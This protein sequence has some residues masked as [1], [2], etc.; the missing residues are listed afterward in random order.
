ML[1]ARR[2]SEMAALIQQNGGVDTDSLARHFGISVMTAR[3][4]L[5]ILEQDNMLK[6]TWGGAVP[7]HFIA[8]ETPYASKAGSMPEAKKAIAAEAAQLVQEESCIILDA[9]TTTLELAE[10]LRGRTVTVVTPDLQIALLLS[11]SPTVTVFV[12]GGWLDPV[13]RSCNDQSAVDF[14][15][16]LSVTQAFLGTNAWDAVRGVTTSV[17]AKMRMKRQMVACAEQAILLADSSK[18][19]TFSPWSVGALSDFSC[20]ISDSGLSRQACETVTAADGILTLVSVVSESEC[21]PA[22]TA[23]LP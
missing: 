21:A 13:S 1:P 5:K 15:S 17:P 2:R 20:V 16:P 11:S 9:G 18:F 3:R 14:L 4:D 19:G 7:P 23:E 12:T 22:V 10:L 6:R 8:H